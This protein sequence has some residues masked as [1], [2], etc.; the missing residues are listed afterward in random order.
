[1]GRWKQP[2]KVLLINSTP[3]VLWLAA[4]FT[5]IPQYAFFFHWNFVNLPLIFSQCFCVQIFSP[6]FKFLEY[7]QC[8][9]IMFLQ[10][11]KNFSST[12][13]SFGWSIKLTQE[14]NGAK[15]NVIAHLWE[16]H[17]KY[18]TQGQIS[19]LRLICH[20]ELRNGIGFWAAKQKT[21]IY[22]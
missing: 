6:G 10:G 11:R 9:F 16:P 1:M 7:T 15:T 21:V 19:Q 13:L 2:L 18:E 4:A 17:K 22:R 3:G 5:P 14:I 8:F 20:P 12:L